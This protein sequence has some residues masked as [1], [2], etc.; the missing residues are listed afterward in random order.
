MET[1]SQILTN[2]PKITEIKYDF[3]AY[4]NNYSN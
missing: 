4:K 2:N 1:I 3:N